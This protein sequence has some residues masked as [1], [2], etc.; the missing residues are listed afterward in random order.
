MYMQ[1]RHL[2]EDIKE[3]LYSYSFGLNGRKHKVAFLNSTLKEQDHIMECLS[4][5][6]LTVCN[7]I[8]TE[9]T[10]IFLRS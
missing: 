5:I 2:L 1:R 7:L 6:K 4:K 9:T 3:D 10:F 8:I